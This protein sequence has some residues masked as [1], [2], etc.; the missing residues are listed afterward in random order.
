MEAGRVT[1]FFSTSVELICS[2]FDHM[3][4]VVQVT[5]SAASLLIATS[6]QPKL[7]STPAFS[8]H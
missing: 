2:F 5:A 1:D 4:E 7:Q 8:Q 3:Q 6:A